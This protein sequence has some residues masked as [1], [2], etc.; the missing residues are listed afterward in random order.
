[1][2]RTILTGILALAAG[3]SG[4][5]AQ[6]AA[7]AQPQPKPKSAAEGKAVNAI[8]SAANDPDATIKAAEDLLTKYADTDFKEYALTMEARAYQQKRDEVNAQIFAERV[9]QINPKSYTMEVLLAEVIIPSIKEHDLDR[10]EKLTKCTT[11][12]SDSIENVKVAAK[13]N[14]QVSDADWAGA[15]KFAIGEAHNGLGML[16]LIDKKW[17][18][19]IKEFQLA[20]ENDPEQDAYAT[21][22]ASAELS[23]GKYPDCI[24]ICDKLLAKP[25]L[26]PQIKNVVTN[27]RNTAAS[28]K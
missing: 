14:A 25:T 13:P 18:D 12:L 3:L 20:L 11:L 19:A 17:D 4:L 7:P 27:I 6:P 23:A 22:L 15:Q 10:K 1:M 2:K 24:A 9:L 26:N 21:R 16:A 28:R 8:I 5:W